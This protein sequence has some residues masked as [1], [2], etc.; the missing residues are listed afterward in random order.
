MSSCLQNV[1]GYNR[2][3]LAE[4]VFDVEHELFNEGKNDLTPQDNRLNETMG[5]RVCEFCVNFV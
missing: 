3:A 5:E 4:A 2:A 1:N